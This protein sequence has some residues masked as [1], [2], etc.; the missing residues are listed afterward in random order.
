M[1]LKTFLHQCVQ[2]Y[3][4]NID[5]HVNKQWNIEDMHVRC[6]NV[7]QLFLMSYFNNNLLRGQDFNIKIVRV[8]QVLH[9]TDGR[10]QYLRRSHNFD[11]E[12]AIS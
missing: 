1:R 11:I 6:A 8:S 3:Q 5:K 4:S 2:Q 10:E 7:W 12:W 9:D